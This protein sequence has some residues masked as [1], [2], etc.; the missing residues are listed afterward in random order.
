MRKLLTI[1]LTILLFPTATF[2]NQLSNEFIN[3]SLSNN[4][5]FKKFKERSDIMENF[6]SGSVNIKDIKFYYAGREDTKSGQFY[7]FYIKENKPVLLISEETT[8]F[9]KEFS[10][11]QTFAPRSVEISDLNNDDSVDLNFL[12]TEKL[13]SGSFKIGASY[14]AQ[15]GPATAIG[16]SDSNFY[17]TGNKLSGDLSI[18][19]DSIFYDLS[20]NK[21]YLGRYTIDNEYRL[22]N[23]EED[24]IKT[25]GYKRKATGIDFSIKIPLEYDISKDEY[26]AFALGYENT[27]NYSLTSTA[28]NSV[29]QNI[30]SSNNVYLNTSYTIDSRNDNFNPTYGKLNQITLRYSPSERSDDDFIKITTRNN[31]YFT[32]AETDNSFFILSKLGIASGLSSKIKTKDSF[33]LGGDFK[34]FQYSGIG[35]RDD[36]LNYLGGTKM[37]QLTFGYASPFLFDDSDTFIIKYFATIGSV[38]DSEYTS[39]YNSNIPRT[40]IGASLDV[41][42]PIGPLSFSLASPI[43]KNAKD[44]TQIYDFSIGSTF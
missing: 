8:F 22:F 27:E 11:I 31:F 26:Y 43:S 32:R 3:K 17:G 34:G 9:V 18:S 13:K 20:L 15:V 7:I 1:L 42:T 30:G 39:K 2:A 21:F 5:V 40:S 25:Y 6:F 38:F 16:L 23:K 28:S 35:P 29:K 12:V 10:Q 41:M 37:Y 4:N 19:S 44:K 14:S 33:V 36:S 24:L